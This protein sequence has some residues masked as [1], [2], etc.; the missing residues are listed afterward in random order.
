MQNLKNRPKVHQINKWSAQKMQHF[1]LKYGVTKVQS[2]VKWKY[3]STSTF[4]MP[5]TVL[6]C[7]S[8]GSL[9]TH[10]HSHWRAFR[11]FNHMRPVGALTPPCDPLSL[12]SS[13]LPS[14]F[15]SFLSERLVL[16]PAIAIPQLSHAHKHTH[17][18]PHHSAGFFFSFLQRSFLWPLI[19]PTALF[20]E[21][22]RI[23]SPHSHLRLCGRISSTKGL[24]LSDHLI[25][26][27]A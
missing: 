11:V 4:K 26:I 10:H 25:T 15:F 1:S 13:P 2:N 8:K 12:H 14:S 19:S 23:I 16:L 3:S 18:L 27:H 6:S 22:N 9:K 21:L 17:S 24:A 20:D 5:R 7:F